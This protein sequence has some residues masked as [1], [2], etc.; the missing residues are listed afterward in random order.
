MRRGNVPI[1]GLRSRGRNIASSLA[2]LGASVVMTM[3]IFGEQ[4]QG[5]L[6]R[7]H[8]IEQIYEDLGAGE[9]DLREV[10]SERMVLTVPM[11]TD[12]SPR[13]HEA[14]IGLN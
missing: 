5:R 13:R 4:P 10:I 14:Q 11:P 2:A 7:T 1:T 9:F 8:A 3:R 12:S 6:S